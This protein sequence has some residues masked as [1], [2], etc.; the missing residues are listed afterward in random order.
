MRYFY[1]GIYLEK[2]QNLIL[3]EQLLKRILRCMQNGKC[4]RSD[5]VTLNEFV[6]EIQFLHMMQNDE[7][8]IIEK[9]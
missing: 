9:K 3:L 4:V 1:D 6:I 5:T 2:T 8:S 7:F